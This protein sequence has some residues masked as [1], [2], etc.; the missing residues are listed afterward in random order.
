[1]TQTRFSQSVAPNEM[2]SLPAPTLMSLLEIGIGFP[3]GPRF[4]ILHGSP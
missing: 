3:S 2:K 1:M 4:T